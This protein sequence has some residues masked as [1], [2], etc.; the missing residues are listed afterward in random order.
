M[1]LGEYNNMR[2]WSIPDDEDPNLD[3][4][5]VKYSDEYISWSPKE[6]FERAYLQMECDNKIDAKDVERFI[7]T[8][9]SH[10]LGDKTTVV[11]A[12]LVNG[13][14]ITEASSCVD[15]ENFDMEIGEVICKERITEQVWKLL[16]FLLQT[17]ISGVNQ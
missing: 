8:F 9:E 5:L 11:Q 10:Q 17:A 13:F 12:T 4:Y 3:G 6:V 2:G 7:K 16:G 14:V 1:N 15:P